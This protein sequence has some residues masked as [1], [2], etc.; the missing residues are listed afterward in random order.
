[1]AFTQIDPEFQPG[2]LD[3]NTFRR[4]SRATAHSVLEVPPDGAPRH[5]SARRC[6][7]RRSIQAASWPEDHASV[8]RRCSKIEPPAYRHTDPQSSQASHPTRRVPGAKRLTS[9]K[10]INSRRAARAAASRERKKFSSISRLL[11]PGP[12]ARPDLRMR[13]VCAPSQELAVGILQ[14][15]RLPSPG[16]PSNLATAPENTQGWR[17][18][19]ISRAQVSA[20]TQAFRSDQPSYPP[21]RSHPWRVRF[22]RFVG[23]VTVARRRARPGGTAGETTGRTNM[24]WC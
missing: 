4:L 23:A 8:P 3:L 10:G 5:P 11:F 18:N 7:P 17:R 24:S 14:A 9:P 21:P 19:K 16:S 1:M 12:D 20:A 22:P 13:A 2:F 15:Q 6:T